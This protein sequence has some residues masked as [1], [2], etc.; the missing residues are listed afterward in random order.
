MRD[1]KTRELKDEIQVTEAEIYGYWL[2]DGGN[3]GPVAG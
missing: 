3:G 1:R 2:A